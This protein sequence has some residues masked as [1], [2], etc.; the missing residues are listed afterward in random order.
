M[1]VADFWLLQIKEVQ[2]MYE[3][4]LNALDDELNII[5]RENEDLRDE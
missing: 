3:D 1:Y 4:S 5:R 2:D